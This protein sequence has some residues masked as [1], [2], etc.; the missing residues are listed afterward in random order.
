M[1]YQIIYGSTETRAFTSLELAELLR[2]ARI[3]NAGLGITGMLLYHDRSFMQ[4]L[5]GDKE[6]V[7]AL[8]DKIQRDSRHGGVTVFCRSQSVQREFGEWSMA[9][10][11]P[12][13][14]E[15][16]G[17][18]GFKDVYAVAPGEFQSS[19]VRVFMKSFRALTRMDKPD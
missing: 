15:I 4:I 9:F 8:F 3:N 18:G 7:D 12:T 1:I 10:H 6:K 17:V 5:E 13:D 11:A 14:D 2:K 19:K 16:A